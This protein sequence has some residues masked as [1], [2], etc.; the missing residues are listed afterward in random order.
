MQCRFLFKLLGQRIR[1]ER[2]KRGLSQ[3]EF[4]GRSHLD[5]TYLARIETGKANPSMRVLFRISK[6][7]KI[8]LCE[9][10]PRTR[11]CESPKEVIP[12]R[13]EGE[14]IADP[15]SA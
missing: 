15:K 3:E 10:V 12:L 6:I 13:H 14:D 5:R 9:L 2:K 7:I 11:T 1:Q 4:S 8:E